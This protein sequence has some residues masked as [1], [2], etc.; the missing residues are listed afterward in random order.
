[1]VEKSI[2]LRRSSLPLFD[3]DQEFERQVIVDREEGQYLGHVTQVLL[4]DQKTIL[5]VY[6]KG[7]GRGPIVLKLSTDGGQSWSERLPVPASWSTSRE[8]PTIYEM[9]DAAGKRRLGVFSGLYPI[10]LAI[11]E[12]EG[13]TWSELERI[14]DF[15]GIVAMSDVVALPEPGHYLAFFHDDGRFIQG[16]DNLHWGSP[17]GENDG[18][19]VYAVKSE[20]GGL[21][22][23]KPRV[24]IEHPQAM[25][26]EAGAVWSPDGRQLALL[27]R[28]NSRAFNSMVSFSDDWGQSWT[29]PR[30][31]PSSLTGDRH[32][33]R[34]VPDGRLVIAFRDMA[35]FSATKGDFVVWVG[36]YDDLRQGREGQYRLRLKTNYKGDDSTYPGVSVLPDGTVVATTYGHWTEGEEPYIISVRFSLNEIDSRLGTDPRSI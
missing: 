15:G 8:C 22:W 27:L 14:G 3:L 5:A 4:H 11:S 34:Y 35:K 16:G 9:I 18:M 17:A 33:A 29:E 10:R 12:D 24:I 26:C 31:L 36:T 23:G 19:R 28:E 13:L 1:M 21:T 25:L 30:Q 32:T 2:S 20:D 7:H 6:P